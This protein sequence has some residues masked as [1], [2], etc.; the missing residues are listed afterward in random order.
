[1]KITKKFQVF[2]SSTFRDLAVHRRDAMMGIIK[3]GHM[4]LALEYYGSETA[5]KVDVL[6]TAILDCQ[7]YV[8]ILGATYGSIGTGKE[9]RNKKSYV[10]LEY[11][12]A[13]SKGL[14]I[15]AFIMKDD[16]VKKI[17]NN[18]KRPSDEEEIRHEDKYYKFR[19]KLTNKANGI[20]YRPFE[21]PEE[22]FTELYGYFKEPHDSIK[23]YILEKD[24]LD[25]E[26]SVRCYGTKHNVP[27]NKIFWDDL[28]TRAKEK[29][30]L[31]GQ[32]NKSWIGRGE[33]EQKELLGES[34]AHIIQ[35]G[36]K[37]F[38][39]SSTN[40]ETIVNTKKFIKTYIRPLL[41]TNKNY[42]NFKESLIYGS[43]DNI[44]YNAVVSD[45]RLI[46]MPRLNDNKFLDEAMV[47]EI[48][49]QSR[50]DIFY[51][52]HDDVAATVAKSKK[53][54]IFND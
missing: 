29:F 10:E 21:R 53:H 6:K 47:I 19:K 48:T 11:E 42:P 49:K 14:Q 33:E 3:A 36:G 39:L 31:V 25:F 37:V 8:L 5:G 35:K 7:F 30:I 27:N 1:M 9:N 46:I 43:T 17:R 12:Y 44:H 2:L 41:I 24:I 45:S 52:Y 34:I 4:P 51:H 23:G 28:L 50:S 32:T 38:I 15:L 16:L 20:Y 18:L 13:V 22:I 40:K 26:N 54:D